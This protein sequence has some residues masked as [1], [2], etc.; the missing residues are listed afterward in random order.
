MTEPDPYFCTCCVTHGCRIRRQPGWFRC[1]LCRHLL[2]RRFREADGITDL[3][4]KLRL[5]GS[6][7][8]LLNGLADAAAEGR[9]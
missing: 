7:G 8:E 4:Q 5:V 2:A 9:N 1:S 3:E 6:A